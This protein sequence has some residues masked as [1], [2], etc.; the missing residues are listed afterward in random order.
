MASTPQP[1]ETERSFVRV[2][3]SKKALQDTW[4]P[5]FYW[6]YLVNR[7]LRVSCFAGNNRLR[8]ALSK[9]NALDRSFTD[10]DTPVFRTIARIAS[11]QKSISVA[12]TETFKGNKRKV[13][14]LRVTLSNS[15]MAAQEMMPTKRDSIVQHFQDQY[16]KYDK[17]VHSSSQHGSSHMR[18]R[19]EL[20]VDTTFAS[21]EHNTTARVTP[22]P[23]STQAASAATT[24]SLP[25]TNEDPPPNEEQAIIT[26][27][28]SDTE[29]D[30]CLLPADILALLSGIVKET[31]LT[32]DMF[33]DGNRSYAEL[34]KRVQ[35]LGCGEN[36]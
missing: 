10:A 18:K 36:T 19:K 35:R 16:D 9:R 27:P 13:F 14:F 8:S 15:N 20:T 29:D 34:R 30:N 23:Q 4:I 26:P 24:R 33:V 3:C 25:P 22:E 6:S 17:L 1:L 2:A 5:L 11:N 31:V 21:A 32:E 28:A 7:E 12:P